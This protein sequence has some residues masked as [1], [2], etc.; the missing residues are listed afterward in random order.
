[1]SSARRTGK[2]GSAKDE[3]VRAA[4]GV[5]WRRRDDGTLDVMIV[6]R[7]QYDDWS[8]PKGK[9]DPGESDETAAVREVEEETG[10]R[11]RLGEELGMVRYSDRHGRPKHVRYWAMTSVDPFSDAVAAADDEEVDMSRWV[12]LD[13]ARELL[14]YDRDR[15]LLDRLDR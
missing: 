8:L 3:V 4:G 2:D 10:H 1:M 5:L 9:L 14:S 12:D 6:H 15:E 7:P 13:E 11:C